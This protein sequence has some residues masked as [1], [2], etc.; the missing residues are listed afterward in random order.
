MPIEK[1]LFFLV[2]TAP[3][4]TATPDPSHI[5]ACPRRIYLAKMFPLQMN[6]KRQISCLLTTKKEQQINTKKQMS[7]SLATKKE[8]SFNRI[9]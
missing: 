6:T 1:F 4:Q 9:P 8:R 3:A 2:G 5:S 7:C